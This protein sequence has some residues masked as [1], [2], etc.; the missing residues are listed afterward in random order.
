M[1]KKCLYCYKSLDTEIIGDFHE[2][3]SVAF[4]GIRQQPVFE[5][6]LTQ[7]AELA[8]NVVERSV[9]VP[10]VQPKLSL[11]IVDD[12]IQDTKKGRLT[13]VGAL[14][15][16]YIFKPPSDQFPEMP[17]NE[18]LTMRIAESFGIR[19]VSS[20]LIRL[21][22]GELSYITKRID[23]TDTGEKIHMLD[24]FQITEAFD[25]YKSSMEKI[26]KALNDYSDNTLLDKLAFFEL[27]IFSFLTGNNDMHLKNF[28]MI[29]IA[30]TWTLA[31]AYDL[32]NVAII[33][34]EDTEEL[35][36]TIEGKKKKLKW[37]HF[38]RLGKKL[39]LNDKQISGVIK[40]FEK[41][42]PKAIKWIDNSF[43]SSEYKQKYKTLLEERYTTLFK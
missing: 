10:G 15:G 28:S 33:I 12:T 19:T 35:A 14:G 25:K 24:M 5:H 21:Q 26:G 20:S 39:E 13:V 40:R 34:P 22:S 23:R 2:Q 7:M 11:S 17:E 41:N 37:E 8:K 30:D 42:K 27:A 29:H 4:F 9:A 16:N 3:C 1:N 31:P 36:L 6:S 38:E 43:L 32:L 18:H